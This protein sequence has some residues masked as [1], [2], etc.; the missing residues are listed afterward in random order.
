[1]STGRIFCRVIPVTKSRKFNGLI[2]TMALGGGAAGIFECPHTRKHKC[3]SIRFFIIGSGFS[4][5]A[6]SMAIE[7]LRTANRNCFATSASKW[8]LGVHDGARCARRR[9]GVV[10]T[11]S[12]LALPERNR[13]QPCRERTGQT[14]GFCLLPASISPS[15]STTSRCLAWLRRGE[16]IA[17]ASPSAAC[18]KPAPT[19][20]P[21]WPGL[22]RSA[23]RLR[24]SL[25]KPAGLFRGLTPR[26]M[27]YAMR[28]MRSGN[29]HPCVRRHRG[30]RHDLRHDR[31]G[32]ERHA[33]QRICEMALNR[34]NRVAITHHRQRL[35]LPRGVLGVQETPRCMSDH[36]N[37]MEDSERAVADRDRRA[38]AGLVARSRSK[39]LLQTGMGRSPAPTIWK[40]GL[41]RARHPADDPVSQVPCRGGWLPAGFVSGLAFS[42]NATR[43]A[44]QT[45]RP[46]RGR[47]AEDASSNKAAA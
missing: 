29:L 16:Q 36:A 27:V 31:R 41:T 22:P 45:A 1:M 17:A 47:R 11:R 14:N 39:R 43:R 6:F 12:H 10:D 38:D 21:T 19:S 9:Y 2:A 18:A 24:H 28:S 30:T 25:E 32:H 34:F 46:S 7:P 20:W 5:I 13:T 3:R 37:L 4:M 42:P 15:A 44:L 35:P 26:H 23:V 40:S 33:G 8:R